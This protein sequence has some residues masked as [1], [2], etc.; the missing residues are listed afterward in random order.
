MKSIDRLNQ[1]RRVAAFTLIELLVVIAIIG[2]LAGLIFPVVGMVNRNKQLALA[3]GQL[4][5]I[6]QAIEAYH[7]K[8]GYY[9]PDNPTNVV[10][11]P[12]YFELMGTTNDGATAVG[13][14]PQNYGTLDGSAA[15]SPGQLNTYFNVKGVANTS[16]HVHSD[17]SG[18]A[19][20]S[21]LTH[22]FQNQYA[23][24]DPNNANNAQKVL[25]LVC[26]IPWP[27]N[28]GSLTA[29]PNGLNPWRYCSS[30][31]TNNVGSYDLWVDLVIRNKTN[32]VCNWSANPIVL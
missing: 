25:I 20:S 22:L 21:F 14:T 23:S 18:S 4:Q 26:P 3:K 30:H 27:A 11:N 5:Q 28:L 12:L 31:P 6:E 32:R 24:L 16:T 7:T 15:A 9:P 8:L 19:A 2:I 10:V 29:N 17:D 1:R 13:G